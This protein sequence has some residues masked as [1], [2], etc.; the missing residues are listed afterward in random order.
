MKWDYGEW[1]HPTSYAECELCTKYDHGSKT[2]KEGI[3][4]TERLQVTCCAGEYN[5]TAITMKVEKLNRTASEV[6]YDMKRFLRVLT[7]LATGNENLA[8]ALF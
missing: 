6:A 7:Y 1:K 2:C 3:K 4:I 5:M 8:L